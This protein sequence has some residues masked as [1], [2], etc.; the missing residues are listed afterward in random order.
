MTGLCIHGWLRTATIGECSM[1]CRD[2]RG[3]GPGSVAEP[4]LTD[5]SGRT[6]VCSSGGRTS[7]SSDWSG[8][9]GSVEPVRLP[10]CAAPSRSARGVPGEVGSGTAPADFADL[11]IS[12][13][14][15]SASPAGLGGWSESSCP[16]GSEGSPTGPMSVLGSWS[17]GPV[18]GSSCPCGGESASAFESEGEFVRAMWSRT[19]D[20]SEADNVEVAASV[21]LG[22]TSRPE[23]RSRMI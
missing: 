10:T 18:A 11:C 3:L 5:S 15:D 6:S 22:S 7:C 19:C 17:S 20:C 4:A 9:A 16:V 1:T 2:D 21:S 12:G 13:S 23:N 8:S 14:F